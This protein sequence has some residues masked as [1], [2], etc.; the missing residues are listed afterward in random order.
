VIDGVV[1]MSRDEPRLYAG[2]ARIVAVEWQSGCGS[3]AA[4]LVAKA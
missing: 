1:S 3:P 4:M 2:P